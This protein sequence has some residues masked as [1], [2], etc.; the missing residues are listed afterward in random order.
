MYTHYSHLGSRMARWEKY[1][2]A[3]ERGY[4]RQ[5]RLFDLVYQLIPKLFNSSECSTTD[6]SSRDS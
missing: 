2:M 5:R 3:F 4:A 6:R 1:L